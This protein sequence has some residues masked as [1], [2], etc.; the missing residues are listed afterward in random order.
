M[1]TSNS[2]P[3]GTEGGKPVSEER[4]LTVGQYLRQERERKNISLE[5]V[6]KVTLFHP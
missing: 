2:F 3:S 4:G 5:D 1:A 6:A